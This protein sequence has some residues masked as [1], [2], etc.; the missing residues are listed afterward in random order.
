MSDEVD[1]RAIL[2][3]ASHSVR[4]IFNHRGRGK[5]LGFDDPEEFSDINEVKALCP[6]CGQSIVEMTPWDGVE[7]A[8]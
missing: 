3:N 4:V 8:T 2:P 6:H 1:Y 5:P 7:G